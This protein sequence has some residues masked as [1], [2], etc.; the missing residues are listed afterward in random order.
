LSTSDPEREREPAGE[1]ERVKACTVAQGFE[2][3]Q[4]YGGD[5]RTF[6][7]SCLKIC[8]QG[9]WSQWRKGSSQDTGPSRASSQDRAVGII[10]REMS[11]PF[12][13]FSCEAGKE[14]RKEEGRRRDAE[15]PLW[16]WWRG[17][18]E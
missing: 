10:W 3:R 17:E 16:L 6:G 9:S 8:G 18:R 2:G 14:E 1:T 4:T 7:I 12:L 15:G 13:F 5:G 11:T